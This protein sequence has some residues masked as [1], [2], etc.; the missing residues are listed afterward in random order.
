MEGGEHYGSQ[1]NSKEGRKEDRE[2]G[3]KE[4][5]KEGSKEDRKEA[6]VVFLYS[7]PKEKQNPIVSTRGF[8]RLGKELRERII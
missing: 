8:C 4:G 7:I 5:G 1:E 6:T 2:E 3:G